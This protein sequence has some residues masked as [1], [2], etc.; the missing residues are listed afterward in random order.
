MHLQGCVPNKVISYKNID[1]T[2]RHEDII[3]T[4]N[5]TNI[6]EIKN[7]NQY[8]CIIITCKQFVHDNNDVQSKQDHGHRQ[9]VQ[10][11]CHRYKISFVGKDTH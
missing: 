9:N 11:T 4:R 10:H 5:C 2:S 3:S 8:S 1:D 7:I 6:L